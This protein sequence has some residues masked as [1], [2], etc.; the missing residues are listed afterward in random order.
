[1]GHKFMTMFLTWREKQTQEE[2][3]L[4]ALTQMKEGDREK[5]EAI[6]EQWLIEVEE[7]GERQYV[8]RDLKEGESLVVEIDEDG[9]GWV[10]V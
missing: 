8:I 1:M 2:E 7:G 4:L 6:E 9:E 10:L 3:G 5:A